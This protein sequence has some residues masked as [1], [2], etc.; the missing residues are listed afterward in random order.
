MLL[1]NARYVMAAE[2]GGNYARLT[3]PG[4]LHL[5]NNH[6]FT[7]EGWLYFRS[8]DGRD[9]MVSKNN[10]RAGGSYDYLLGSREN[11]TYVAA[12][13]GSNWNDIS[14][15]L[16]QDQWLHMAF[17]YDGTTMRYYI[18]GQKIGETGFS[19]SSSTSHDIKLG[20]YGSA[21]DDID[22]KRSEHRMWDHART[23]AEIQGAMNIQLNGDE[24]GLIAYYPLDEG[25]GETATD[26]TGNGHDMTIYGGSWAW[27]LWGGP[28]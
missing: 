1:P 10:G 27:G 11:N 5:S 28:G 2:G 6:P 15:S 18:D 7:W 12:Y 19:W 3:D 23:Q 8:F 26:A 24:A 14:Y 13:D 17:S 16:P 25:E 9:I 22:G 21:R 20:G 4:S